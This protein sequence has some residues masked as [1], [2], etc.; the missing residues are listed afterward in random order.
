MRAQHII[1]R[2]IYQWLPAF[3]LAAV[4]LSTPAWAA[5][6]WHNQVKKLAGRGAVL[7]AE[8]GQKPIFSWHPDKKQAPASVLKIITAA[9]ALDY[10]GPDYRFVTEFYATPE[11]DLIV[12]GH[13]DP[14]LVSEELNYIGHMIRSKGLTSVRNIYLDNSYFQPNLV[15]DGTE[16]SLNPYDAYNGALCANF[17]TIFARIDRSGKV[18]S[19]EP[20]TPITDLGRKLALKSGVKG[21]VRFNLVEHPE[22]CLL[23]AGDLIKAFLEKNGIQVTGDLKPEPMPVSR[24]RLVY[25]HHSRLNLAEL[26]V[27][28]M[29]YSNNFMTNQVFLTLG[30][31]KYGPPADAAKARRAVS[32]FLKGLGLSGFHIEEGSGLSRLNQ[33]TAQQLM[34]VLEHF[35]PYQNLLPVEEGTLVKTGTLSDV[36]SLAGYIRRAPDRT[37]P[38]VILL[39][40]R[41]RTS[42]RTK[43]LE[44][45]ELNIQ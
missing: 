27:Q 33:I 36:K 31:E 17:N 9:A 12:V 38:F 20:Q 23:Y 45:L 39:N 8:P 18:E 42:T 28:L 1:H 32:E 13:G 10:L 2:L 25:R 11:N 15:L 40:G 3:L 7:V 16:R 4:V 35:M 5:P 24:A 22:T 30:A 41:Y 29:K 19:A 21:K 34:K 43:I 37:I 26:T 6:A 44:I 14:Y